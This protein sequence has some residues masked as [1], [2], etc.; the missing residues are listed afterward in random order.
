LEAGIGTG[1][2]ERLDSGRT[3]I[4]DGSVR[5]CHTAG[6]GHVGISARAD[7]IDNDIPLA[8]RIPA[9]RAGDADHRRV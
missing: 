8:C 2:Q 1:A 5:W 6:G 7:E 4:S 3:S 9:R